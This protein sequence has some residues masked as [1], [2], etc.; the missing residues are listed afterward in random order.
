[1]SINQSEKDE[2]SRKEAL[3]K[4]LPTNRRELS[5]FLTKY[6][7]IQKLTKTGRLE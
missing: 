1:M 2:K 5:E 4:V 7:N 6:D 3:N